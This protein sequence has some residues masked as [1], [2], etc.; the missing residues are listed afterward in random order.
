MPIILF[1]VEFV[2]RKKPMNV[3]RL[4]VALRANEDRAVAACFAVAG[5]FPKTCNVG[6]DEQQQRVSETCN[7]GLDLWLYPV[8]A[9]FICPINLLG[10]S[11][12]PLEQN[13]VLSFST[14]V[15]GRAPAAVLPKIK[16]K[17]KGGDTDRRKQITWL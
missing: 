2:E 10:T 5:V 6:L 16:N 9:F 3:P 8:W 7:E 17:S 14:L 12:S 4:T 13:C 11:R 1:Y 15:Q